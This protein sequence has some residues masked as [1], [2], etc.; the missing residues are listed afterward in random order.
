MEI[1]DF[2]SE[3]LSRFIALMFLYSISSVCLSG[4]PDKVDVGPLGL[5]S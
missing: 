2:Q 3:K 5:T 4:T 1:H